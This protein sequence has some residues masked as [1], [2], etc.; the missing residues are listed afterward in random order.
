[1]RDAGKE[2]SHKRAIYGY[3]DVIDK[4]CFP[5]SLSM[6]QIVVFSGDEPADYYLSDLFA[7]LSTVI[8]SK[9]SEKIHV[10]EGQFYK[11]L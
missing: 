8:A 11:P 3:S 2:V 4:Y 1:M 7:I 10:Q 9:P 6:I 5:T